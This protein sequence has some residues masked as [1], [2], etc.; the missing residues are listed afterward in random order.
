MNPDSQSHTAHVLKHAARTARE[1]GMG[2]AGPT[3]GM[4]GESWLAA[5]HI[6]GSIPLRVGR[7]SV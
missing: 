4:Y 7:L 3:L 5:L 6:L 2:L 1:S